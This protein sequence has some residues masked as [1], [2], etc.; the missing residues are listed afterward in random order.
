MERRTIIP[1]NTCSL[2]DYNVSFANTKVIKRTQAENET[3]ILPFFFSVSSIYPVFA[4]TTTR[5]KKKGEKWVSV[6]LLL[7]FSHGEKIETKVP[8]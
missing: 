2:L 3:E 1:A 5:D 7:V 8:N 4:R 6:F